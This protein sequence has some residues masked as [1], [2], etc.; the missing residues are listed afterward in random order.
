MLTRTGLSP[1]PATCSECEH[2]LSVWWAEISLQGKW[3]ASCELQTYPYHR[4]V[5]GVSIII[6]LGKQ[7][8]L[9]TIGV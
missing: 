1:H 5:L 4:T 6:E 7:T 3:F 8:N 2:S 9:A